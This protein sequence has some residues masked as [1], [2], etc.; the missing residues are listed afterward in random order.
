MKTKMTAKRWTIVAIAICL[1]SLIGTSLV[2]TSN[3]KIRIKNMAWESPEGVL[4][5][6]DLWIPPNATADTP[7]PAI[8]TIEGWYNNKEM[9]DMYNVELSRRGFVILTLDM[10]GHGNSEAVS[11]DNLYDGA[12]GVDAAVQMV[13]T[14]PYVD[15]TKIGVK[16]GRAHV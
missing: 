10:H 5:S 7:A 12:V 2:Q 13:A 3:N 4:L 11:S 1:I 15:K 14:L 9:Q 6:A 8:V 16:I